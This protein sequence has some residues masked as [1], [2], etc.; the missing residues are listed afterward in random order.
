MTLEIGPTGDI[1]RVRWIVE[2]QRRVFVEFRNGQTA[3]LN[4]DDPVDWDAGNV[5]L[6]TRD[7]ARTSFE[8]VP[9]ELWPEESWVGVVRLHLT[10]VIVI[11]TSGRL[12]LVPTSD[13][14][15]KASARR[16]TSP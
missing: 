15:C 5:L 13:V 3:T 7:G 1:V 4:S 9:A 12:R 11:D 8:R 14:D 10:D 2:D 16:S 6:L